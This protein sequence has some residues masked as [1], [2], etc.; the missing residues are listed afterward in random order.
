MLRDQSATSRS[1]NAP[2]ASRARVVAKLACGSTLITTREA[3]RLICDNLFYFAAQF[4]KTRTHITAKSL[5]QSSAAARKHRRCQ[6]CR[7]RQSRQT[8]DSLRRNTT[9]QC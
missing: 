2:H 7:C 1:D 6:Q 4:L 5:D 3:A 9:A 8:G